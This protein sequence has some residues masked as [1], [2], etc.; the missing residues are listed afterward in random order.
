MLRKKWTLF[1]FSLLFFIN[2]TVF[3]TSAEIL[4]H[5]ISIQALTALPSYHIMINRSVLD[6]TQ[7]AVAAYRCNGVIM[8]P[9]RGTAEQLGYTV[10]WDPQERM[11]RVDT[12]TAFM[13]IYPGSD[14]YHCIRTVKV[15]P[16]DRT[17]Q[18]G[19]GPIIR[20]DRLYVPVQVFEA[21]FND[22][23][24]HDNDV[25]VTSKVDSSQ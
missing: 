2:S 24:I 9:L 14:W 22:V 5:I 7:L 25:S 4:H 16:P 18:Y 13:Y 6:T 10:T 21:F 1:F 15:S 8:V 19:A 3:A 12:N 20:H 17:Y 11:A 23:V